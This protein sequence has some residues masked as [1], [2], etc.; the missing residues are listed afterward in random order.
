MNLKILILCITATAVTATSHKHHLRHEPGQHDI[1][2]RATKGRLHRLLNDND[3]EV[4]PN[5]HLEALRVLRGSQ[6]SLKKCEDNLGNEWSC[7]KDTEEC[8]DDQDECDEVCNEKKDC[9]DHGKCHHGECECDEGYEDDNDCGSRDIEY[10]VMVPEALG[11]TSDCIDALERLVQNLDLPST[12]SVDSKSKKSSDESDEG[13][14]LVNIS[15]APSLTCNTEELVGLAIIEVETVMSSRLND[16]AEDQ[17]PLPP[18]YG[19]L[20]ER[21]EDILKKAKNEKDAKDLEE[22]L[23]ELLSECNVDV[24]DEDCVE[25]CHHAIEDD[26]KDEV[27]PDEED[28]NDCGDLDKKLEKCYKKC[29]GL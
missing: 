9:N 8:G 21:S 14:L 16:E 26:C 2:F 29:H 10:I 18:S 17:V 5:R 23:N 25:K 11:R 12:M 1:S 20:V 28:E 24:D 7:N 27:D 3:N 13:P 4:A 22:D 6:R 15:I 19:C